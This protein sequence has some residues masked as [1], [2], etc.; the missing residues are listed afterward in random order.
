M[1]LSGKENYHTA[2]YSII[3]SV[4]NDKITSQMVLGTAYKRL[5]GWQPKPCPCFAE[6]APLRLLLI[7]V[8]PLEIPFFHSYFSTKPSLRVV[9]RVPSLSL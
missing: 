6:V 9:R 8:K 5:D 3:S 2:P 7:V 4:Q 1:L